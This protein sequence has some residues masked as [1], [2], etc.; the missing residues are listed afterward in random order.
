M[1][2]ETYKKGEKT[3]NLQ[4]K[5]NHLQTGRLSFLV[6]LQGCDSWHIL[7]SDLLF[8]KKIFEG[9]FFS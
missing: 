8:L 1:L 6:S 3:P 9:V 2:K 4:Q 7:T 5:K